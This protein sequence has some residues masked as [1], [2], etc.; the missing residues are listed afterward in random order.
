[1]I[2]V[3]LWW[4][5]RCDTIPIHQSKSEE[6]VNALIENIIARYCVP[7]YISMDQYSAS[8]SLFMNYLFKKFYIKIKIVASYINNN[9][10]EAFGIVL[11]MN[12]T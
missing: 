3:K 8:K 11:C 4:P 9:N 5:F 1:M 7:K 12:H 2:K 6:I 10:N